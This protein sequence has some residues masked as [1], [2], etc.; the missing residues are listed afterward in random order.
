MFPAGAATSRTGRTLLPADGSVNIYE[1]VDA[2]DASDRF[3]GKVF[4]DRRD[5]LRLQDGGGIRKDQN[6]SRR[7]FN[8][9]FLCRLLSFLDAGP[10]E[11]NTRG[12]E[13]SYDVIS[14]VCRTVR[15]YHDV[16]E[17]PG[18]LKS[19]GILHFFA[20]PFFFIVGGD[21][22]GDARL[23]RD[24]LRTTAADHPHE[25]KEQRISRIGVKDKSCRDPE[26]GLGAAE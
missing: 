4:H 5:G 14:R 7:G 19:E 22:E 18:I 20:N 24:V 11:T 9:Q 2:A 23:V 16:K 26:Q 25:E 12:L 17:L 1:A 13:R 15:R 10:N 21:D 8:R 3:I 6:L